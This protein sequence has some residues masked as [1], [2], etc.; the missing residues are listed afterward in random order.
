MSNSTDYTKKSDK[1]P[2]NSFNKKPD[3]DEKARKDGMVP[4]V[5]KV[6]SGKVVTRKRGFASRFSDVLFS[7]DADSVGSYILYEIT[8]PAFKNLIVDAVT[9]GLQRIMWG[10]GSHPGSIFR[11][12][13]NKVSYDKVYSRSSTSSRDR[14]Q[15][16]QKSGGYVEEFIFESRNEAETVLNTLESII[17]DFDV[18]RVSD[19]YSLVGKTPNFTDNRWGWTNLS[20]SQILPSREGYVIRLPRAEPIQRN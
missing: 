20:S 16:R 8:I 18:A 9:Q 13:V 2:S 1:Y 7:E 14:V 5:E 17:D 4:D 3:P 12:S 11:S 10:T 19:M 6:V 15:P